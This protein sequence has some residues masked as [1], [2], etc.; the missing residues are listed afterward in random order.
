MIESKRSVNRPYIFL[1]ALTL[2]SKF[3]GIQLVLHKCSLI[4]L[5]ECC[6]W[7]Q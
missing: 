7:S 6:R 3:P 5:L 1:L 4:D 2:P